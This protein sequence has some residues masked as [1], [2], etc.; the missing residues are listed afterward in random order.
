MNAAMK[1][2]AEKKTRYECTV[3]PLKGIGKSTSK[4]TIQ[5]LLTY[6]KFRSRNQKGMVCP[7]NFHEDK[8]PRMFD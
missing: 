7:R 2:E 6:L 3:P 8:C 4:K 5:D 1:R